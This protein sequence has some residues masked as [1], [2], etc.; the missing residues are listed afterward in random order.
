MTTDAC[1]MT[2]L[3]SVLCFHMHH[4]NKVLNTTT[5]SYF[6]L[7]AERTLQKTYA[8][9][10]LYEKDISWGFKCNRYNFIY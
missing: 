4:F 9:A 5:L 2:V 3:R 10:Q 1:C 6:Y 7:G 8:V